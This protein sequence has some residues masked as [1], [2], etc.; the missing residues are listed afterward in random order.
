LLRLFVQNLDGK[1]L[2]E[3]HKQLNTIET[4]NPEVVYETCIGQKLFNVNADDLG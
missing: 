2:F 1:L 4:I 3:R